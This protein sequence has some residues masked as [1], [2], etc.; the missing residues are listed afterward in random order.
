MQLIPNL[1]S[2]EPGMYLVD[3]P[4]GPSSHDIVN[5]FRRKSG[6]KKVGHAGTLDPL[7]SGLL[8]IL[9]GKAFTKQQSLY[10]K[11]DKEYLVTIKFGQSTDSYDQWGQITQETAWQ[12][13]EVLNRQAVLQ[14]LA[15]FRGQINQTVP[16]FSAVKIKGEKLYQKAR[17]GEKVKLP[18]RSV[19]INHLLLKKFKKDKV[20]KNIT[21]DL[22]INCSSGTYVRSLAHDLG[23]QLKVGAHV[24]ALRREKIGTLEVKKSLKMEWDNRPYERHQS[25]PAANS[26]KKLVQ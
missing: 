19:K 20:K 6:L 8:I 25:L 17:R 18:S 10:L 7:A 5:F 15:S 4:S 16:I 2:I 13:L 21:A 24:I 9:V 12:E 11:Q 1:K 3:K 22:L 26:G 23:Q 14:A